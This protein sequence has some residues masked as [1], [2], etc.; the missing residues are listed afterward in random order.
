MTRR[1]FLSGMFSKD[2]AKDLY[3][4][5]Q[6]F[7]SEV[8]KVNVPTGDTELCKFAQKISKKSNLFRKEGKN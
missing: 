3:R 4:T 7:N 2:H 6:G 8:K 5:W 1:E